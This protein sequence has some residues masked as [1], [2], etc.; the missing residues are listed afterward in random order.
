MLEALRARRRP[1]YR[2]AVR[3]GFRGH[4]I[5]R[6]QVAAREAGVPV[7][8]LEAKAFERRAPEGANPQGVML[9]V[10]ALPEKRRW[11]WHRCGR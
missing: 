1:L 11:T 8:S 10:G 3:A 7:E 5:Q 6:I 2:L 4:E 9:W